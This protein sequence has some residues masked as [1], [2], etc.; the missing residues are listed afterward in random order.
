MLSQLTFL[1]NY[2]SERVTF[3]GARS[4]VYPDAVEEPGLSFDIVL[5]QGFRFL[6]AEAELNLEARN[7]FGRPNIASARIMARAA[8]STSTATTWAPAFRRG[9]RYGSR[10]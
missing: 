1:V 7:I 6:G 5:R 4:P 8:S 2:A 3:R 9:C 10:M